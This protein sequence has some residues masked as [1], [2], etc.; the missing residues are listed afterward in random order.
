MNI[1]PLIRIPT[2]RPPRTTRAQFALFSLAVAGPALLPPL[3]APAG[4]QVP[5]DV[6]P[7]WEALVAEHRAALDT[8]G[9][10]GA[11][12]ALVRDGEIAAVEYHGLADRSSNRPVD[13]RTI[14]HWASITKT[15]TGVAVMQL[16]DRG[17][18]DLDDPVVDYVPELREVHDP[19]GPISDVTLRHLLTHSSG[20]RNS[21]WPW[22]EG[23]AWQ[24]FEPTEWSQLVAMMPYTR[25]HFA[26]GSRYGYSNPGVIF[27]GRTLERVTGDVFEA[28]IDKNLI[29]ALGMESAYLDGTPWR[30][31]PDRSNSYRVVDGEPVARGLDFN[32]G[33]TVSNGGLNA[34]VADMAKWV[35]FVAGA[36]AGDEAA[37]QR[38]AAYD[39]VLARTS[40]EEMWSPVV[41]VEDHPTLGPVRMGLSFFLYDGD[42]RLVVGHTGSQHSFRSFIL[43]DPASGLGLIGAWNTADGDATAPDTDALRDLIMARA[44]EEVLPRGAAR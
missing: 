31:L 16:R 9:I 44:L 33:I 37:G 15:F 11:T 38:P 23:A 42:G 10:V 21:T 26:P 1:S 43:V 34:S 41:P 24:P 39:A 40:L 17:L 25:L 12:L 36:A 7:A 32:T 18:L 3:T 2:T 22:D 27:L 13:E 19:Y 28:Y 5:P 8:A 4:A 6:A 14:Y 35:G 29:A 30:L 20:F